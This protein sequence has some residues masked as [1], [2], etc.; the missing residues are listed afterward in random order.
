MPSLRKLPLY[1]LIGLLLAALLLAMEL[2][3]GSS[4]VALGK[5]LD[6]TLG[7]GGSLLLPWLYKL[8]PDLAQ[9]VGAVL[10]A[11]QQWAWSWPAALLYGFPGIVLA[12]PVLVGGLGMLIWARVG[13]RL[14]ARRTGSPDAD[15]APPLS[16]NH[17]PHRRE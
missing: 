16:D 17:H 6:S 3:T 11:R 4:R 7:A 2:Y 5:E 14:R 9:C 8:S 10:H 13:S 1:L 15:T 12:V